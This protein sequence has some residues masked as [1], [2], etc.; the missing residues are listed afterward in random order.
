MPAKTSIDRARQ[1]IGAAIGQRVVESSSPGT[2]FLGFFDSHQLARWER[3]IG[4]RGGT[5][6]E[7]CGEA[8][9]G[10]RNTKTV[11]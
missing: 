5:S 2:E 8:V 7:L 10:P 1:L 6:A 9:S 3:I 4:A 11:A